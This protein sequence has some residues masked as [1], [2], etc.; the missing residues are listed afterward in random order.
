[1]YFYKNYSL[2]NDEDAQQECPNWSLAI[3][4]IFSQNLPVKFAVRCRLNL[5][6]VTQEM[7][8]AS[9]KIFKNCHLL[10]DIFLNECSPKWPIILC[11][12]K[13]FPTLDGAGDEREGN[14]FWY[15]KYI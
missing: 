9:K 5:D 12:F 10:R 3:D 11:N 15:N 6:D 1:M 4:S 14:F 13:H 2:L 8:Y 7:F